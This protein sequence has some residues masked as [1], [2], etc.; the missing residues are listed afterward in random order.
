[1]I[2]VKKVADAADM[3]IQGYAF[4]K[5]GNFVRVLN[6]HAPERAAVIDEDLEMVETTMEDIEV[7]IVTEYLRKNRQYMEVVSA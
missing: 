4:T 3:I 7:S 1:M 6:L 2:D 5:A